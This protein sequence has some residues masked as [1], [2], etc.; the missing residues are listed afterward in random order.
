MAVDSAK[1]V[2]EKRTEMGTA[3]CR[4]LRKKGV[5][6]GNVYGH[7]QGSIAIGVS[8]D[9]I[10]TLAR[11]GTKV[12]DL[13]IDGASEKA[14]FREFQWDTFGRY[15]QHF[16]LVRIDA[17][18]RVTVEVAIE[19]RGIAPGTLAGGNLVQPLRTLRIEC[20]AIEIPESISVRVGGLEIGESICVSDLELPETVVVQNPPETTIVQVVAPV[21]EDAEQEEGMDSGPVEPEVIGRK[22]EEEEDA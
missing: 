14:M 1:L 11:S 12:L 6:P 4:R 19:V 21:D 15:I 7:G 13:E 3:A 22:A 9:A 17:D 5:V 8:A 20:L 18:E 10:D 2:A 16:D